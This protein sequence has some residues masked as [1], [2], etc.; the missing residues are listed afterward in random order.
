MNITRQSIMRYEI[1]DFSTFLNKKP[2]FNV[3]KQE[4]N[5]MMEP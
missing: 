1:E 2:I 3:V 5:E 4:S